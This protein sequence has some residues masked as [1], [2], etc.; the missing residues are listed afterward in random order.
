MPRK[1]TF[2]LYALEPERKLGKLLNTF[3]EWLG[4]ELD[5][6]VDL[7]E[8]SD[9]ETLADRMKQGVID[10]AWLPPIV[11]VRVG[12]D[13]AH[14]LVA[15]KRGTR[16]GFETALVVREDSAMKRVEDLRG[17]RAAWVDPWSAAGYVIPRLR[18]RLGGIDATALFSEEHF[19]GTHSAAVR[20]V[21]DGE[22]DVAGT[23]V[24]TDANG[25]VIDGPWSN[26][27]DARIRVLAK[28]D[29]IPADVFAVAPSV[30]EDL[31]ASLSALLIG[32]AKDTKHADMV[33]QLFGADGFGPVALE[34]YEGLRV[35]LTISDWDDISK[36]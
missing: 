19:F 2:G 12:K 1:L 36:A 5:A 15:I 18:L 11:F 31:R 8:S 28:F 16:G 33:K 21:F 24:H 26:I 35:A 20:A 29:E 9:Y 27:P 30:P 6:E 32:S 17:C 4:K 13:A 23:Y 34:S 3:C 7:D 14:P 10:V 25:E 22:A